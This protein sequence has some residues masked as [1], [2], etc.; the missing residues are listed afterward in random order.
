[1]CAVDSLRV[2][3]IAVPWSVIGNALVFLVVVA[4][5]AVTLKWI[6]M[7]LKEKLRVR[8]A[9]ERE[10]KRRRALLEESVRTHLL[11]A[12]GKRGFEPAP[13]V[14]RGPVDRKAVGIFP[15][16]GRLIR[17]REPIVD[18]VEI[19]FSTYGRAA[20]RINACAVP[21]EGMMTAWGHETAEECLAH[22]VHDLETHARPWLRPT[23][24]ALRIEPV[25]QWF[26]VRHWPLRSRIQADYD[27]LALRVVDILPE[28]ELA[29]R[30]GKLGPHMLRL[31]LKPLPPEVLERIRKL[32]S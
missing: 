4:I 20:F 16:W 5:L 15:S 31:E 18:Q 8:R 9:Q 10:A 27:N 32:S 26:S 28:L 23:L 21:K 14:R 11:P 2:V 19:Q 6:R 3:L 30:E 24:R 12:L 29:L 17:V 13:L 22:G 7:P 1:L 25:G